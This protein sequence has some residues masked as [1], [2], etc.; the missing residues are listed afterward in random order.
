MQPAQTLNNKIVELIRRAT[1]LKATHVAVRT[2]FFALSFC[3]IL[4]IWQKIVPLPLNVFLLYGTIVVLTTLSGILWGYRVKIVPLHL[5]ILA[6]KKFGFKEC[7]STAYE[8][9]SKQIEHPFTKPLLEKAGAYIEKVKADQLLPFSLPRETFY[10]PFL[11]VGIVVV[12]LINIRLPQSQGDFLTSLE[13]EG[14]QIEQLGTQLESLARREGLER[15]LEASNQIKKLGEELQKTPLNREESFSRVSRLAE[16]MRRQREELKKSLLMDEFHVSNITRLLD[17]HPNFSTDLQSVLK[18]LSSRNLSRERIGQ[19]EKILNSLAK[20]S[21]LARE[22]ERA[23]SAL[24][25]D[26]F[27]NASRMLDNIWSQFKRAREFENLDKAQR[28]LDTAARG[29][30]G[31]FIEPEADENRMFDGYAGEASPLTPFIG[32]EWG[33]TGKDDNLLEGDDAPIGMTTDVAGS[34]RS[35]GGR[36][37]A[38]DF[39]SEELPPEISKLPNQ[40]EE[41]KVRTLIVKAL[42][43][44]NE[45]KVSKERILVTYQKAIEALI[46]K[47]EIP[48][49]LKDPVK[50]YFLTIGMVDPNR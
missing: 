16:Q 34:K 35:L 25:A 39:P 29:M 8:F 30:R 37:G 41:G 32:D 18:E 21:P 27:E 2:L 10:I 45:A 49:E 17:D 19:L 38:D 5:L 20:D 28:S 6:D 47:E 24:K 9:L 46:L 48:P 11:V 43:L 3:L 22:V 36:Q 12:S 4:A 33:A 7:L 26:D 23:L 1:R 50:Q 44:K 42:P 14:E 13:K 31:D 40:L 15:S